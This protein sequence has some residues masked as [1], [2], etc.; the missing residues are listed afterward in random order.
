MIPWII[1][2]TNKYKQ[3][4]ST[5]VLIK[6]SKKFNP[7]LSDQDWIRQLKD[8]VQPELSQSDSS[9]NQDLFFLKKN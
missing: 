9:G 6:I 4:T 5:G 2:L 3:K 8:R 7:V 1:K